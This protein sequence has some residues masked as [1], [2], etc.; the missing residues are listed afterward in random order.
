MLS[1][2]TGGSSTRTHWD[3]PVRA[4]HA[5][6]CERPGRRPCERLAHRSNASHTA[7]A[8]PGGFL[9]FADDRDLPL[10]WGLASASLGELVA[11]SSTDLVPRGADGKVLRGDSPNGELARTSSTKLVTARRERQSFEGRQPQFRKHCLQNCLEFESFA[12]HQSSTIK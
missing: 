2:F 10:R 4:V 1:T 11:T 5:Y 3:D 8:V 12:H 7:S 9:F 6:P